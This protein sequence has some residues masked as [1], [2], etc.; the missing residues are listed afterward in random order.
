MK[1]FCKTIAWIVLSIV[2]AA[3]ALTGLNKILQKPSV[4][5]T[6]T[7]CDPTCWYG[8]HPGQEEPYA[9]YTALSKIKEV[10]PDSLI[11]EN[12]RDDRISDIHWN[13]QRPAPDGTGAIYFNDDR[14][15]AISITTVNS[16]RLGE[17]FDKLGEPERYWT[18]IGQREYGEYARIYLFYPAKGY[19][20][21]V[22]IDFEPGATQVEIRRSTPVFRVTYFDP[23]LFQDLLE[24]RILIDEPAKTRRGSFV[25]W[26]GF[27]MLPIEN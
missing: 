21:D 20:A 8:I 4:I 5:L 18:E 19:L 3:G 11:I 26:S 9:I 27:G 12:D 6:S 17:L 16:I 23:D 25:P 2:V 15:T 13:F 7:Q 14:V 1:E 10:N 22:L 24:T